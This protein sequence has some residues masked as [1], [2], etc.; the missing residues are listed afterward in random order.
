MYQRSEHIQSAI[1]VTTGFDETSTIHYLSRLRN[2]G[3]KVKLVGPK[4][5]LITGANG[6]I[7]QPD[8]TLGG[9]SSDSSLQL[10]IIPDHVSSIESLLVDPRFYRL[11]QSSLE[12]G[13]C[14]AIT[15]GVQSAMSQAGLLDIIKESFC[16]NELNNP[17]TDLF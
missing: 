2:S 15:S 12:N 13:G 3:R 5:G 17:I 10:L 11:I 7:I 9:L 1:L 16:L 14:L 8:D 6:L 4:A